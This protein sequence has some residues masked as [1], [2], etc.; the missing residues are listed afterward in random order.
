MTPAHSDEP[1]TLRHDRVAWW[2]LLVGIYLRVLPL[3][4]WQNM[5]CVRDECAYLLLAKRIASGLGMTPTATGWLW[6]PGYPALLATHA[7]AFDAPATIKGLQVFASFIGLI[8][9]YKLARQVGGRRAARVAIWLGAL[10]PTFVFFSAMLWSEAIYTPLLL[11][12]LAALGWARAGGAARAL[13]PGALVGFCVLFRGVA[14]YMLPI[15]ALGLVWQ[16]WRE[17]RAWVSIAALGL[18]AALIVAPYSAS[19]TARWGGTVISDRTLGQMMWLGNNDFAPMTFDYGNGTLSERQY[20]TTAAM[21]RPHCAFDGDP[22]AWDTCEVQAGLDWIRRNPEVFVQ[23]IPVRLAQILNPNSFLT[24]HLRWGKW[25]GTPDWVVDG[26]CALTVVWSG[27]AVIGGAVGLFARGR[28]WLAVVTAGVV[29]Y[30][31]AAIGLLAGLSRYRVP[32]DALLLLWSAAL[33]AHL[34]A[35]LRSLWNTPWR[36]VGCLLTLG[37]LVPLFLRYLPAGFP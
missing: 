6:A 24:R 32:L 8:L 33:I 29:L 10:S 21:G 16:R 20:A 26:L 3:A 7:W 27:L 37:V 30:H 15:F 19:A 1:G 31:L 5:L 4:V 14:T 17:P 12:A 9:T 23:R 18:G 34:P 2:A 22:V 25:R 28:S 35:D 13:A 36:M 11:G